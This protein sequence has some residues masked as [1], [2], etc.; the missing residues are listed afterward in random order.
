[1]STDLACREWYHAAQA[2]RTA[3]DELEFDP[4]ST[5]TI[6]EEGSEDEKPDGSAVQTTTGG[7]PSSAQD[8]KTTPQGAQQEMASEKLR[9]QEMVALALCFLGPILGTGLLH[10]IR[11]QLSRPSEGLVSNFNLTIFLLMAELRPSSHLISMMQARTLHLQRIARG[12]SSTGDSVRG[13]QVQ[14]LNKRLNEVE[15]RLADVVMQDSK[16]DG[17]D[18]KDAIATEVIN[19]IRRMWQPQLDDLTRAVRRYEKRATTQ[20]MQTE[21]RLQ[22]LENRLRD[23][24]ALAAAAAKSGQKPGV[25]ALGLEWMS[26]MFMLPLQAARISVV[27]PLQLALAPLSTAKAWVLGPSPDQRRRPQSKAEDHSAINGHRVQS[28]LGRR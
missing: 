24:L 25:I 5:S 22:D 1:M 12:N 20:T 14:E 19:N 11:S 21:A 18:G 27:Y 28:K 16:N 9:N 8:P 15:A 7:L 4:M 17:R 26:A 6:I 10:A 2:V 23:A 13:E 3:E